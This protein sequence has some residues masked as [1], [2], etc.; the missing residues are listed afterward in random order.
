[1]L[2]TG[3]GATTAASSTVPASATSAP[4]L[5]SIR[6]AHHPGFDLLVF[7][8]RGRVPAH[9]SATYVKQ[10]REDPRGNIVRIK[11]KAKLRVR[12]YFANGY[13]HGHTYNLPGIIQVVNVGDFEAVL[14]FGVG[15]SRH[16]PFH[17]FKL[18]N[19]SRVVIDIKTR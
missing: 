7:Q 3:L 12:F 6:A 15:V 18:T 13:V 1:M 2:M 8:F 10:V 4:V 11:G 17:M 9:R 14:T 16:A 5:T 19:P